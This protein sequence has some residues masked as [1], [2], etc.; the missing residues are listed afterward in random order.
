[1]SFKQRRIL[2]HCY[3]QA[4]LIFTQYGLSCRQLRQINHTANATQ[5]H[6]YIYVLMP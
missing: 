1:M 2:E 6:I 5:P 4:A 3:L